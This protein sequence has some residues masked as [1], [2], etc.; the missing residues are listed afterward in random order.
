MSA[1][2]CLKESLD[3]CPTISLPAGGD[4]GLG[5]FQGYHEYFNS[6]VRKTFIWPLDGA[7]TTG[8]AVRFREA[9]KS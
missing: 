2:S 5:L 8:N 6:N 3:S 9:F 4:D 1:I 7:Q